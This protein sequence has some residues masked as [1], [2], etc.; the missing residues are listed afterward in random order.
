MRLPPPFRRRPTAA[1]RV[2]ALRAPRPAA[3]WIV[4]AALAVAATVYGVAWWLLAGLPAAPTAQQAAEAAA[5]SEIIRTA[6]AAGAGSG[7][8][9]TL[10]L[11]FRRQRHQELDAHV[12]ADL[13][14]RNAELAVQVARQNERDATERR[15][16]ELYTKAAE[17]LGHDK[18]A[19]R[20]A[21]LYAL[22]RLAQDNPGHRQTVVNVVC[23]YLR[24]PYTLPRLPD[25]G[26][27][28]RDVFRRYRTTGKTSTPAAAVPAAGADPEGERQVR[29]TA[30]RVL[31]DHLRDE[32][33]FGERETVPAGERHWTGIR[34]DLTGAL[35]IDLD[36]SRC[37]TTEAVFR[38]ASFSGDA[39]FAYATFSGDAAFQRATFSGG[40][41]FDRAVFAGSA[42]FGQATFSA[43]AW[44]DGTT[45]SAIAWFEGATFTDT[46]WFIDATFS[47]D[48]EFAGA[49]FAEEA[50]LTGSR[51]V[52]KPDP[53]W[54]AERRWPAGWT[55]VRDPDGDGFL[56]SQP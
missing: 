39:D 35:L 27:A 26:R 33:P 52:G 56:E 2:P 41:R 28:R 45:F 44:F 30:Q 51:V 38:D 24:M 36:F 46:A 20:L 10:M 48:T 11:A 6:L 34:V 55:V 18:A 17:Q 42:G 14:E 53:H 3:W 8:A 32:R 1:T 4:P 9:I 50:M 47:P 54:E 12:T 15:I 43:D 22:E 31:A 21:G 25:P 29:L 23:A 37:T 5:R 40:A 16:T 7:A 49:T 19:V 13:A